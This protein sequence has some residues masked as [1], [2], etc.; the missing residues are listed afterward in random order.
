MAVTTITPDDS[1]FETADDTKALAPADTAGVDTLNVAAGA[2]LIT[3]GTPGALGNSAG[4]YLGNK[5][6]WTVNVAGGITSE[7]DVGIFLVAGN[8]GTSV[9]NVS[10]DGE[11]G[12]GAIGITPPAR[13]PSI[14]PVPSQAPA[15]PPSSSTTPK[16]TPSTI[17]A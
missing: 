8:T 9:I 6:A 7:K 2:Y 13:S 17:P 4:A 3:T 11:V 15:V 10:A 1:V 12:G 16:P 5:M 14:M